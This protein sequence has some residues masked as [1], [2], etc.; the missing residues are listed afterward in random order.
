MTKTITAN[1][2]VNC[3]L[4]VMV[5]A[6]LSLWAIDTTILSPKQTQRARNAGITA[7]K[8]TITIQKDSVQTAAGQNAKAD[9]KAKTAQ[10]KSW[11]AMAFERDPD[12]PKLQMYL[13]KGLNDEYYLDLY[14]ILELDDT[15]SETLRDLL[16][17]KMLAAR[18][19]FRER[20]DTPSFVDA[21]GIKE[22]VNSE[23]DEKIS[24][25]LGPEKFAQLREYETTL[26]ERNQIKQFRSEL[27]FSGEP[28]TLDQ[29]LALLP[30]ME[31]YV[32][33]DPRLS[34]MAKSLAQT[35]PLS[36]VA[37]L[38]FSTEDLNKFK[39]VLTPGQIETLAASR[40][41]RNNWRSIS[42]P[43]ITM[44]AQMRRKK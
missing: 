2:I 41:R 37:A 34:R 27:E 32:T 36:A 40:E 8:S 30:A 17:A 42:Y 16:A 20:G 31:N 5:C 6:C 26:P 1:R 28:L 43:W 18:N 4:V 11:D 24:A 38:Q 44:G 10:P 9:S 19:A 12:F 14:K 15:T 23:Y 21:S 13:T 29:E 35:N 3:V 39:E 25:L 33:N 7:A 22:R